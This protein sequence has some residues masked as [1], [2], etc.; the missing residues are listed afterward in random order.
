MHESP[1]LLR[2]LGR[3]RCKRPYALSR[4]VV[5]ATGTHDKTHTKNQ[6]AIKNYGR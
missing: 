5:S 6:G 2:G 3:I 4:E 1:L